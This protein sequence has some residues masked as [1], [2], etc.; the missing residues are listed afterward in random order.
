M[1]ESNPAA[2]SGQTLGLRHPGPEAVP[3]EHARAGGDRGRLLP[4]HVPEEEH[5]LTS[6]RTDTREFATSL[7]RRSSRR[8]TAGRGGQGKPAFA[9]TCYPPG[10]VPGACASAAGGSVS[11]LRRPPRQTL[12]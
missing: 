11:R 3:S 1:A 7:T 6:R 5:V 10:A 9:K 12:P 2:V 8:Q 4:S